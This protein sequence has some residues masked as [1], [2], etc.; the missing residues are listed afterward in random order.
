MVGDEGIFWVSKSLRFLG[1][2][3][4]VVL[5]SSERSLGESFLVVSQHFSREQ[6]IRIQKEKRSN[7]RVRWCVVTP[8]GLDTTGRCLNNPPLHVL[9][10]R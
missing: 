8:H 7:L 4:E 6:M 2:L 10:D 1:S 3:D 9:K 5:C